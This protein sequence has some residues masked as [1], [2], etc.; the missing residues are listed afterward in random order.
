TAGSRSKATAAWRCSSCCCSAAGSRGA[1]RSAR[2]CTGRQNHLP[3]PGHDLGDDTA[4]R[5]DLQR[6]ARQRNG[7]PRRRAVGGAA[8]VAAALAVAVVVALAA[9]APE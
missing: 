4:V 6:A 2:S 7:S 9:P 1:E 3:C 5:S 8:F